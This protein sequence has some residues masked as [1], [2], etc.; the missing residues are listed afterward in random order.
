MSEH[1]DDMGG[2]KMI[3]STVLKTLYRD[4]ERDM[5]KLRFIHLDPNVPI[6][7]KK[8]LLPSTHPQARR[9][10]FRELIR[11]RE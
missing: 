9:R 6:S 11:R 5:V 10:T 2:Y 7:F 8:I 1:N 3:L 4:R